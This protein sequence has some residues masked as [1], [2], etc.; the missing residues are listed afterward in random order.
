L[1]TPYPDVATYVGEVMS[2]SPLRESGAKL[3]L[4]QTGVGR[5]VADI[6]RRAGLIFESVTI[7]AGDSEVKVGPHEW[8][9]PKGLL[10]NAVD[11]RLA[12]RELR[13]ADRLRDAKAMQEELKNFR[14]QISAT[15]HM[16]FNARSGSFDDQILACAMAIW[17]CGARQSRGSFS[18]GWISGL[19]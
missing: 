11:A 16:T 12:T 7:T 2:R 10:I 17:W 4:D 3:I 1:N 5:P 15:G 18:Q 6:M 13:F 19:Y 14:R 9:V 8:R